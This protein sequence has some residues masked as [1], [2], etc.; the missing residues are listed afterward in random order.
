MFDLYFEDF[1]LNKIQVKSS[2]QILMFNN[3][4]KD[5]TVALNVSNAELLNIFQK[6]KMRC[7]TLNLIPCSNSRKDGEQNEPY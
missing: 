5:E 6:V 7:E 1:S 4:E 2:E 3:K